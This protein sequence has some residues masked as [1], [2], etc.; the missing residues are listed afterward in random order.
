MI[1]DFILN[2]EDVSARADPLEPLSS[3]LAGRF[4]LSSV[5]RD[6]G[7]GVCG[8][9]AA[10]LDGRLV[11]SCLVPAFKARGSE[12]VTFE[13]FKSTPAHAIVKAAFDEAGA[14]PCPSC[15]AAKLLAIGSLLDSTAKPDEAMLAEAASS[16]YCRCSPPS[17]TLAA[18]R[19]AVDKGFGSGYG[20]NR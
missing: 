10:F 7:S 16:V 18:A 5:P 13:G 1:I 14:E 12:V 2:G 3:I 19:K 17:A 15:E 6:C 9:C 11:N 20:R 8:K 4:G